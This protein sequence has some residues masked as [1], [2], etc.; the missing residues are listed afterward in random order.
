VNLTATNAGGSSTT[1]TQEIT[2]GVVPTSS[3]TIA[4]DTGATPF[5]AVFTFTGSGAD[6]YLWDFGDSST[7]NNTA[8]N[9][10]HT[11]SS[12]DDF[13]VHVTAT[14]TFGSTQSSDGTVH[15]GTATVASFT[16]DKTSGVA[17][18]VVQFTSTATGATS[19]YWVFGDGSTSTLE[20]PSHQYA[21]VGV[22]N[23]NLTTFNTY[24]QSTSA[25]QG[26]TTGALPAASFT[27]TPNVGTA[28][29]NV[30]FTST[31]TGADSYYW[32]YGDGATSTEQNPTHNFQY[33]GVYNVNLTVT[34]TYGSNQSSTSTIDILVPPT[35]VLWTAN[36]SESTAQTTTNDRVVKFTPSFTGTNTGVSY[37]WDIRGIPGITTWYA[38]GITSSTTIEP[39]LTFESY[40]GA[41]PLGYG[42]IN[43]TVTTDAGVGTYN[44]TY[45]VAGLTPR[46]GTMVP[47]QPSGTI[48]PGV[49][50]K[51]GIPMD[52][53]Y[54]AFPYNTTVDFGD[55]T[56]WRYGHPVPE[57]NIPTLNGY[58]TTPLHQFP[59]AGTYTITAY[60]VNIW[61]QGVNHT[62]TYTVV[63][64]P[65]LPAAIMRWSNLNGVT[66]TSVFVGDE[67]YYAFNT[68]S[69]GQ[70][71]PYV[72]LD[73]DLVYWRLYKQDTQTGTWL[74]IPQPKTFTAQYFGT[75]PVP[76]GNIFTITAT[77]LSPYRG[78][79]ASG[80]TAISFAG[81]NIT[82]SVK[83]TPTEAGSYRMYLV[84]VSVDPYVSTQEYYT[85]GY[86]SLTVTG[87]PVDVAKT[88]DWATNFG[89]EAMKMVIAVIVM[90]AAIGVPYF[91]MGREFN[92]YIEIVAAVLGIGACYMMGLVPIWVIIGMV[93]VGVVVIFFM[94]RNGNAGG[95]TGGEAMG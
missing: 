39:I 59:A 88:G 69:N 58:L 30:Q 34:N 14:N 40:S 4:D 20:S 25:T 71:P 65:E 86:S 82:G 85:Y 54:G 95:D 62:Q 78:Y 23:A 5:T 29:L 72:G 92:L 12:N 80:M 84:G 81:A 26:I 2:V 94:S 90:I 75:S 3:F 61:G 36:I 27:R 63:P 24:S 64:V 9:P 57:D 19:Y 77:M 15:T 42:W 38:K 48:Y 18:L 21:T 68:V 31:S 49:D 45:N 51:F 87:K 76:N 35:N 43:L 50:V 37:K 60:G 28:P 33:V 6:S 16:K 1:A 55:G 47:D 44:H 53:L 89:G 56:V 11:F 91:I 83:F 22:Y 17:P 41:Y 73:M 7:T 46:I 32:V 67:T 93:I 79:D 8:Q 10:V 52:A 13:L 66:V 70:D 74:E